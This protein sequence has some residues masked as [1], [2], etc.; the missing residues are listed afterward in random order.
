MARTMKTHGARRRQAP[1]PNAKQGAHHARNRLVPRRRAARPP[2][3]FEVE[4]ASGETEITR[5]GLLGWE[6]EESRGRILRWRGLD[7]EIEAAE[8]ARAQAVRQGGDA[9]ML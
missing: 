6:P 3:Y 5:Y 2:G 9:A 7:P 8:I 4:F 1:F